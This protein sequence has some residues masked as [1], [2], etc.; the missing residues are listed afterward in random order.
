M[1][2]HVVSYKNFGQ[3]GA[4]KSLKD[5]NH[6]LIALKKIRFSN[7]IRS[8]L[9]QSWRLCLKF[10]KIKNWDFSKRVL[11]TVLVQIGHFSILFFMQ[12]KSGK[13]FFYDILK[14]NK[15]LSTKTKRSNSRKIEV[16]LKGLVHGFGQKLAI[17]PTFFS[18]QYCPPFAIF[19]LC[20][21]PP[22]PPFYSW[23]RTRENVFKT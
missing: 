1:T 23:Q 14:G 16:F 5:E 8:I 10:K 20:R 6:C 7:Y 22:P 15:R 4:W 21:P 17:F 19:N 13:C 2:K 11:S 3:N 12:Y 9:L 18:R